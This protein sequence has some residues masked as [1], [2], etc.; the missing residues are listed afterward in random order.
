MEYNSEVLKHQICLHD[1]SVSD[2]QSAG[3]IARSLTGLSKKYCGTLLRVSGSLES[4]ASDL[5][6]LLIKLELRST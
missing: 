4:T 1:V 6:L 5:T 2:G 3:S